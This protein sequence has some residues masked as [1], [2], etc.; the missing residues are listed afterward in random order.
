MLKKLFLIIASGISLALMS[1]PAYAVINVSSA[2][3]TLNDAIVAATAIGAVVL[4]VA[5]TVKV[6]KWITAAIV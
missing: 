1:F 5:A 6:Y 2:T 3:A 4:A